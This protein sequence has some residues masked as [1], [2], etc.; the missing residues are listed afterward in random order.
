[1]R[2]FQLW[3]FINKIPQIVLREWVLA[4]FA[5]CI[6]Q[7]V[8]QCDLSLNGCIHIVQLFKIRRKREDVNILQLYK[9]HKRSENFGKQ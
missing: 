2:Y 9:R 1:M 8:H 3:K 6:N 5:S 4:I 7:F